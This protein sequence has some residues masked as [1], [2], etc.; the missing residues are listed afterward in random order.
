MLPLCYLFLLFSL[1]LHI[2]LSIL[3]A[4]VF[5]PLMECTKHTVTFRFSLSIY[6]YP[7][8]QHGSNSFFLG[9]ML[10][11]DFIKVAFPDHLFQDS[12]NPYPLILFM[13][14]YLSLD[15]LS[16][17]GN[18]TPLQYSC[19]ENPMDGGAWWAAVHGV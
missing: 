17:E 3:G 19:L 12:S 18:G 15:N 5:L 11:W 6:S 1:P 14:F 16:G 8:Y 4:L 2:A 9:Y 7:R 10:K 13:L